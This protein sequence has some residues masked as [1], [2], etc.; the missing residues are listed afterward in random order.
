MDLPESMHE[1]AKVLVSLPSDLTV[2]VNVTTKINDDVPPMFTEYMV[3]RTGETTA[4]R[5][6]I[7][8]D[9][10]MVTKAIVLWIRN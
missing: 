6:I 10:G 4:Y 2:E 1:L 3:P 8:T 7:D 9:G 5:R